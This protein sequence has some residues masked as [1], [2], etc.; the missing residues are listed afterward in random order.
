MPLCTAP[1]SGWGA[2]GNKP[3]PSLRSEKGRASW[4]VFIR[5][6]EVLA[7]FSRRRAVALVA[8]AASVPPSSSLPRA[9]APSISAG[10]ELALLEK[11]PRR[12]QTAWPERAEGMVGLSPGIIPS[13]E[14]LTPGPPEPFSHSFPLAVITLDIRSFPLTCGLTRYLGHSPR[15]TEATF[16]A[17]LVRSSRYASSV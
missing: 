13:L 2:Q 16:C 10:R 11:A 3:L 4:K 7:R 9:F 6:R 1:E 15:S 17:A 5:H 12:A 8:R 14:P